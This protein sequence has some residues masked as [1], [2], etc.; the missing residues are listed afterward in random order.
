MNIV[1]IITHYSQH[2]LIPTLRKPKYLFELSD[3]FCK[4]LKFMGL[5]GLFELDNVRIIGSSN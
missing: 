3:R 5:K 1:T 4:D 2:P